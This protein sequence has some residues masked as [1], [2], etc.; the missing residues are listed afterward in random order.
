MNLRQQ[1]KLLKMRIRK[2]ESDNKL[3]KDIINDY[4]HMREMYDLYNTPRIVNHSYMHFEKYKCMR[5]I[6]PYMSDLEEYE[7]HIRRA[8][9]GDLVEAIKND[10]QYEV[11]EMGKTKT[12]EATIYIGRKE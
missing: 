7:A 12:I 5:V 3:M 8:L 4:P 9:I 1:K 2:L 11:V 10:I 6:P